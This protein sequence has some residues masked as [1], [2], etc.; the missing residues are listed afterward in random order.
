MRGLPPPRANSRSPLQ[1]EYD[2]E[3]DHRSR[4]SLSGSSLSFWHESASITSRRSRPH[5]PGC[6]SGH[7]FLAPASLTSCQRQHHFCSCE[8]L[9]PTTLDPALTPEAALRPGTIFAGI[10][11]WAVLAQPCGCERTSP[12]SGE[13]RSPLQEEYDS[14][15]DHRSR[16]SLSGSSISFWRESA[17][18]TSRR[19]RPHFPG[20][21]SGHHFLALASLTSCQR[22]HH[23]CSCE[24][25]DP[26]L[27]E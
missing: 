4:R 21:S 8:T 7:H 27:R 16:R 3:Y 26:H 13:S 10:S 19:S 14:E 23:F 15:W 1:E 22:Q 6:S 20:C 24:T 11:T 12:S 25:L 18:I 17:S 2:S 5:F 9:D